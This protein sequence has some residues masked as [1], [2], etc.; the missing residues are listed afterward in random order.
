MDAISELEQRASR[1]RAEEEAAEAYS[2]ALT[3][4]LRGKIND[5]GD[6]NMAS[7]AFFATLAMRLKREPDWDI[8]TAVVN[9][10][11]LKYNPEFLLSLSPDERVA[12]LAHEVMHCS[13]A[14]HVRR[15]GREAG[16]WNVACD[17]AVNPLLRDAGFSLPSDVLYPSHYGLDEGLSAEEYYREMPDLEPEHVGGDDPGGCGG[18]QDG[19]QDEAGLRQQ[20]AEWKIATAQAAQMARERGELLGGIERFVQSVTAP[21]VDWRAELRE[22]VNSHAKN[23]Y[24]WVPPNRRFVHMGLYLPSLHSDEL[25]DVVVTC[26]CS[27]SIGEDDLAHFAAEI[28]EI[29]SVG[30]CNV[31]VLYHDSRVLKVQE[32]E[33]TDGPLKLTPVGGGGTDHR[34]VFEWIDRQPLLHQTPTC[35]VC[36]TDLA[37]RFPNRVPGYPVLWATD[38]SKQGPFGRTIRIRRN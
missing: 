8:P 9:G 11:T 32:W 26:D 17:M 4:L 36:L 15:E 33:P 3:R 23:D 31:T 19:A 12:I 24:A 35:V 10:R 16:D 30:Q 13:N 25:G 29:A 7:C 18:V 1:H 6:R 27:G 38:S 5:S 37:S 28:E 14:H 22:F 20:E 2:A 21:Q 34:P